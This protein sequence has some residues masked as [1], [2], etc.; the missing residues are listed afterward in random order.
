[1]VYERSHPIRGESID[2]E[3]GTVYVCVG[4]AGQKPE[5]NHHVKSW[6]SAAAR[7]VPHCVE[8]AV[9]G[10]RLELR[11]FDFRG[12]LFDNTVLQK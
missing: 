2:L 3:H 9:A 10:R 4:G 1:M 6:Q 7:A 12:T 11:A 8:F 5:W